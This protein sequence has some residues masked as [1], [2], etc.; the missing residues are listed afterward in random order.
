[1]TLL[2]GRRRPFPK[3]NKIFTKSPTKS[4][5]Q[6]SHHF[7]HSESLVGWTRVQSRSGTLSGPW[8]GAGLGGPVGGPLPCSPSQRKRT[9]DCQDRLAMLVAMLEA[10]G[11]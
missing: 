9:S 1:M 5:D 10:A 8:S 7:A 6:D 2:V 3:Y 11:V 4:V